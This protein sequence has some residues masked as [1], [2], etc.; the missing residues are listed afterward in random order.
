MVKARKVLGRQRTRHGVCL[1]R[2]Y[3]ETGMRGFGLYP[4]R[5][6]CI[7]IF[8]SYF[9]KH[10]S[11][12]VG[13]TILL[14]FIVVQFAPLS[15][16]AAT[17]TYDFSTSGDYTFDSSKI[18][19]SSGLAQL[20]ATTTPEWYN[21]S[22]G[23]RKK[24][25]IDNT[26]VDGDLTNF[27]VLISTT[28]VDW[29]DTSNGGYVGQSDGGD[30]VFTT[31]SGTS[32]LPYE[33]EK[34]DNTTGEFV[35]WVN[36]DTLSSSV[37]TDIYIYYG[38]ASIA[39]QQDSIEVWDSNYKA[40]FHLNESPDNGSAGHV[41]SNE[42]LNKLA[43]Y[44]FGGTAS[45]TTNGVGKIDGANYLDGSNDFL[46]AS[47]TT[48]IPGAG[49]T[50]QGV[51][52]DG[53]FVY[54]SDTTKIYKY[55]LG[56]VLVTSSTAIADHFGGIDYY[57][58]HIY[59]ATSECP[60]S[61]TSVRQY[62]YKYDT[63]LQKVAE[64][65]I[66]ADF[67]ICAGAIAYHDN[68]FYVAESYFDSANDDKIVKY[69]TSFNTVATYTLNHKCV[70]GIQGIEYIDSLDKFRILCHSTE[71]LDVDTSFTN[72]SIQTGTATFNL[73]GLDVLN[74]TTIL[75]N[76][77]DSRVIRTVYDSVFPT[78]DYYSGY[79]AYTASAWF[80]IDGGAG[81]RR[82]IF[83][84]TPNWGISAEITAANLLAYY[85]QTGTT[86]VQKTT[87]ITPT[88]GVWH[89][90]T[91]VYSADSYSKI[92]YDGSELT[93]YAGTP[94]GSLLLMTGLNVGTYRDADAR[95]FN[96]GLD[97]IRVSNTVR[98]EDWISTEYT[99]QDSPST[100]YSVSSQQVSYDTN[101]PTI[102]PASATT[103]TSFSGFTETSTLNGGAIKYQISNDA[104]TTWYWYDSGWTTTS[105]GD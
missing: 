50:Q 103:F 53:T 80:R 63:D 11:Q 86:A 26:K 52:T 24:I 42:N 28:D 58:G 77:R 64:F 21:S 87:N 23:Y 35:A 8:M 57:D 96:G 81:T 82:F 17:P 76:D 61:G 41:S 75:Y 72:G 39:D 13:A 79:T 12:F 31:E 48:F 37:D 93:S 29:K 65:D 55:T 78:L 49:S 15:A 98:S 20:K 14:A 5:A 27:P 6:F 60:S 59:A 95:Y 102:Q 94:A 43:P 54:I 104:G 18:E 71:Y 51:A 9:S 85:I 62:V 10:T 19:F 40:V 22:W 45:S 70:L 25:T 83:E 68:N 7:Q 16:Y 100:F 73:Q 2:P 46:A 34:Y 91:I 89:S 36:V 99:N 97:E 90:I 30:F 67:T 1:P 84:G 66:S 33:I 38:N 88:T 92:Y 32:T 44:N 3:R 4:W 105:A 69:D 101:N 74:S 56:G 47:S